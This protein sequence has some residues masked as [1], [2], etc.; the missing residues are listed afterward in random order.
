LLAAPA[1]PL[2]AAATAPPL[3]KKYTIIKRMLLY[4]APKF[5]K[6]H[7]LDMFRRIVN[8]P[9]YLKQKSQMESTAWKIISVAGKRPMTL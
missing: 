4:A 9:R 3:H 5:R 6:R 7:E 2:P 1:A 8:E